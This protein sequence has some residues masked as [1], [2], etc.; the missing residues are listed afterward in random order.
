MDIIRRRVAGSD[1][2]GIYYGDLE[3]RCDES[4]LRSLYVCWGLYIMD[5]QEVA[6]YFCTDYNI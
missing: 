5:N 4:E 2:E 6:M 3:H 1:E